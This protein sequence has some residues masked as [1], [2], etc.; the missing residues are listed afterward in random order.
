M[1]E[2]EAKYG[3]W[4]IRFK[5]LILLPMLAV[6]LA[7]GS[8]GRLLTFTNDY[9]IFFGDD[10]PQ[11]LAFEAL[12]NTYT[13]NDNVMFVVAP[14]DGQVFTRETLEAVEWLTEQ[15]WQTPYSNRVDSLSNF[16]HTQAEEDDML[17]Q[18]LYE[19]AANLDDATLSAVRKTA[20]AE[21]SLYKRLLAEDGRVTA[22]NVTVQLPG[23]DPI[24][25]TPEV[26]EFARDLVTKAE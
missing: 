20:M 25:E 1:R 9:R 15:A 21:P 6:I 12:E 22:V 4:V 2:F 13:K 24:A 14:A 3:G 10:N 17:V 18:N 26:V 7:A 19:D 11:M 16:Q 5:W 23:I 8:S